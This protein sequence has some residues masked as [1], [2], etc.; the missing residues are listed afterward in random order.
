MTEF[1]EIFYEKENGDYPVEEQMKDT[2]FANSQS[3]KNSNPCQ[4]QRASA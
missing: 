3:C 4:K 2:D 1:E